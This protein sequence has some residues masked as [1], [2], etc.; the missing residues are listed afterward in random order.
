MGFLAFFVAL[1]DASGLGVR[2][3][4][5]ITSHRVHRSL[6]KMVLFLYFMCAI[7][8][9][10]E[11]YSYRLRTRLSCFKKG[12]FLLQEEHVLVSRKACSSM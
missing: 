5:I 8:M 3:V 6:N 4:K 9:K 12:V 7:Y 11:G 2:V 10:S 1:L